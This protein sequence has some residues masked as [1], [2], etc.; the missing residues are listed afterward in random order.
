VYFALG[1]YRRAVEM[2]RRNLTSLKGDLGRDRLGI[3]GLP[4][5]S[6][7]NA[8]I[9]CL[10]ELGEFEEAVAEGTEAIRI[11]EAAGH[12]FSQ[13]YASYRVG[14][15]HLRRGDLDHAIPL[16]ERAHELCQA[17]SF[18]ALLPW[19][20]AVLGHAYALD[21]RVAAALQLLEQAVEHAA[22]IQFTTLQSLW[23][24]WLSEAYLLAGRRAEAE[25]L[26]QRALEVAHDRQERGN[27][28]HANWQLGEIGSQDDPPDFEQAEARY[29]HAVGLAEE[30]GMRPL[31]AQCRLALG[32]LY[33]RM[34]RPEQARSELSAAGALF[35]LMKLAA[36]A[37]RAE[38]E[39]AS[40]AVSQGRPTLA[41]G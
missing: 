7:R 27:E 40:V 15:V 23:L 24:T 18:P 37:G 12:R 36:G 34:G 29:R 9:W 4:P 16:L 19:T 35:R 22:S 32:L 39:L 14:G 25:R 38:T 26:A 13:V 5:V 11:A 2:L 28:A 30:L 31:L 8:L 33:R 3:A 17:W 1:D 6:I 21:G 41:D 20:E 10:A